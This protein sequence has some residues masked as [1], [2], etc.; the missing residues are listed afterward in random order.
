MGRHVRVGPPRSV[1]PWCPPS[2]PRPGGRGP[3]LW[4]GWSPGQ[5]LAWPGGH[6][7]TP[8]GAVRQNG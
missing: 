5:W 4:A 6:R 7:A 8:P 3:L 2:A 1:R